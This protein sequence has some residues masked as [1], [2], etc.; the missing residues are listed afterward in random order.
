MNEPVTVISSR[1][2]RG[3]CRFTSRQLGGILLSTS[4]LGFNSLDLM[5]NLV[6]K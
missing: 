5:W 1:T 6:V 4:L 3:L 2:E